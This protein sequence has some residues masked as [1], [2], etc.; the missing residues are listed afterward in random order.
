MLF[1]GYQAFQGGLWKSLAPAFRP[2][3]RELFFN[4]LLLSSAVVLSSLLLATPLAWLTTRGQLAGKRL[5]TL[6]CVL[7]LAI[8]SYMMA[9]VLLSVGGDDG[10][11]AQVFHWKIKRISGFWGAWLVLTL[12]NTPYAF[13]NLQAGFAFSDPGLEEASQSLGS[14]AWRTFWRVQFP[15]LLPA[16]GASAMLI[17]LHVI[18]NFEA[19]SLLRFRTFSWELYQVRLLDQQY[20][21]LLSVFMLGLTG[22]A[23]YLEARMLRKLQLSRVGSGSQRIRPP[24]PLRQWAPPAYLLLIAFTIIAVMLPVGSIL[25]W[26]LSKQAGTTTVA[27]SELWKALRCSLQSSL[28]AALGTTIFA[29]PLVYLGV[30]Y[31]SWKTRWVE[32]LSYFGYAI[33]P[34]ALALS[35]VFVALRLV[36][37]LHLTLPLLVVGLTIHFLA[38]A[39]GPIRT[40]LHQLPV[41]LSE[42]ALALGDGRIRAFFRVTLPNLRRGLILSG[43]LVFLSSM[44]ELSIHLILSP[45]GY[46]SL[47]MEVWDRVENVEYASA[48]PY[49]LSILI[50]SSL[51]VLLLFSQHNHTQPKS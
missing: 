45:S 5:W 48:A 20:A 44:K 2:R 26:L 43:A 1:L 42:A 11:F 7:P 30:R 9:Y 22:I 50:C 21:S 32:R 3:F 35:L 36:P 10:L 40:A 46:S 25:Y 6:C 14:S 12:C 18:G 31:P 39:L 27:W 47:A 49:A 24:T 16:I 33:A 28:P 19:V 23:L 37:S 4:T 51:F 34:I 15:Q 8:P 29:L 41:R 17:G 38:E 13:L